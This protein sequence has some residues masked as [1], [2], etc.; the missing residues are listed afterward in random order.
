MINYNGLK[1]LKKTIRPL[2]NLNY[3]NYEILIVDNGSTDGSLNYMDKIDNIRIIKSPK[4]REKNFACDYGISK[5]NG[6]YILLLDNDILIKNLDILG[7]LIQRY[8]ANTGAI[9]LSFYDVGLKKSSSY[10]SYLGY[11]FIKENKLLFLSELYKYDGIRIG[12]PAG[13]CLFILKDRWLEVGGYDKFLKFGGDDNDL[14]IK[15]W[16]RGYNN[17]LYSRTLQ[18]HLGLPER[19][20]NKKYYIKWKEMFY[21]HLY[22]ITKNYSFHNLIFTLIG[23]SLFGFIKSIK[24]SV[25]RL[26]IN[27]FFA[28]FEGYYLF[29]RS[30][31]NA[32]KQR[33]IIQSKRIIKED[34]FL[35][36]KPPNFN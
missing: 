24:Q 28:F 18:V 8:D 23:F 1:Y 4:I 16:L 19:R 6:K 33:K 27:L 26:N 11:Y 7:E 32:L 10:G 34:I 35:K 13:G 20:D 36:I 22:T 12:F 17:Y 9:G 30:L 2:L 5:A 25:V 3:A 29:L 14:G 15:L 31:P 21:A